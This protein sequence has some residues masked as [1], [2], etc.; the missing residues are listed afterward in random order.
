MLRTR[1]SVQAVTVV[2]DPGCDAVTIANPFD[3]ECAGCGRITIPTSAA[4]DFSLPFQKGVR[5]DASSSSRS[6]PDLLQAR[7]IGAE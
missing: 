7:L 1:D 4:A 5:R 2:S 6:E 3:P